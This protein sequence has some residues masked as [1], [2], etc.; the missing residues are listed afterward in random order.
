MFGDMER[1]KVHEV[2][3]GRPWMQTA[4]TALKTSAAKAEGQKKRFAAGI[5]GGGNV[6][7]PVKVKY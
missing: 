6:A 1:Y 3:P 2:S 4:V 7:I 5:P